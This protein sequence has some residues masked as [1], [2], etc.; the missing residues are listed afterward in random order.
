VSNRYPFHWSGL[1]H[2]NKRTLYSV[3]SGGIPG[4]INTSLNFQNKQVYLTP[5]LKS[6]DFFSG[7]AMLISLQ[8][9]DRT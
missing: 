3:I 6:L 8:S 9:A 4:D 7:D 5:L 1:V 2:D